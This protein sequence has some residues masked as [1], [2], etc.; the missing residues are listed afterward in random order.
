MIVHVRSCPVNIRLAGTIFESILQQQRLFIFNEF[1]AVGKGLSESSRPTLPSDLAKIRMNPRETSNG[2]TGVRRGRS[3]NETTGVY[4]VTTRLRNK[5]IRELRANTSLSKEETG[6]QFWKEPT[7]RIYVGYLS[8]QGKVYFLHH[9]LSLP[10]IYI[11][12]SRAHDGRPTH[13]PAELYRIA[14]RV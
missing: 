1:G 11:S 3:A 13:T 12:D 2:R 10:T 6:E 9:D 14:E 5:R 8:F 4:P 7:R